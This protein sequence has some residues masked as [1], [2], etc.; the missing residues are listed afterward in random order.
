MNT[1][2]NLING[3]HNYFGLSFRSVCVPTNYQ[4]ILQFLIEKWK[5][6]STPS[7]PFGTKAVLPIAQLHSSLV[8]DDT[9]VKW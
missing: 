6:R 2:I 1:I 9:L 7:I 4:Q 3:S 5:R 8:M